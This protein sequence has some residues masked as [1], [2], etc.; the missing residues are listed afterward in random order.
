M[1]HILFPYLK[2]LQCMMSVVPLGK[3]CFQFIDGFILCML[4]VERAC[5]EQ[6]PLA[7]WL[8][9]NSWKRLLTIY[10]YMVQYM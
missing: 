9:V 1:L 7:R 5:G 8:G 6:G 2:D 10:Q 3:E 4:E